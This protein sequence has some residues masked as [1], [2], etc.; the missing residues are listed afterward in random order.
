MT[1]AAHAMICIA[2]L[3]MAASAAADEPV[4]ER[5]GEVTYSVPAGWE[6]AAQERIVVLTPNGSSPQQCS[7]VLTPGETLSREAD[8]D[9]WFKGKWE[10]LRK[11]WKV[12]QGGERTAQDGPEGSS[13]QYQAAMLESAVDGKPTRRGLLLYAVHVGDAVHWVVFQTQGAALFNQH[14]KAVNGFLAGLKFAETPSGRASKPT[15]TSKRPPA[16]SRSRG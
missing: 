5:A 12:V 14:K 16:A 4:T 3:C 9:K 2:L 10:A 8:F 15:P 13:V 1:R 7:L 11:G 6:R